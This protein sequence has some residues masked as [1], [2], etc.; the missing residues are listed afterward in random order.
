MKSTTSRILSAAGVRLFAIG[1]ACTVLMTSA[2]AATLTWSTA[3]NQTSTTTNQLRAVSVADQAGNDSVY[4][5]YIQ[6]TGANNRRVNQHST[7]APY[8]LLNQHLSSASEQPKGIAT[9]DRGNVFI[10]Y[11]NSGD[12][13]SFL[14]SHSSSLVTILDTSTNVSPVA[15]G[16]G[17]QKSGL[18]YY[19]YVTYETSGGRVE[20]YDVTDPMNITLDP[21]F[22]TGGVFFIPGANSLRGIEIGADGSLY[23]ASR[24]D[25]N[26][27]NPAAGRV[28]KVSSDLSTTS[29]VQLTRAMD[30]A[31]LG[32][33]VYATS[34]NGTNSLIR[35]LSAT[36][37]TTVED[38]TIAILDGNPYT[39]D[40]NEGWSGIDIDSSGR[41]W[42]G[43]QRYDN[44]GGTQDRLLV[45]SSLVPEPASAFLALVA[46]G[47][48]TLARR[49]RS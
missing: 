46:V 9:D 40:N 1:A 2:G 37:L 6:T 30:V 18:N 34:Y 35:V 23:V 41:I 43:D 29:F 15:G 38:I 39:R 32:G 47:V 16:V 11:R 19:A 42:L 27:P 3:V 10:S 33:N 36:D 12:T 20:R 24:D 25:S 5:G 7:T 17:V 44:V 48:C 49:R 22:G 14:R 21:T 26:L 4:V 28:Y 45:S 31:L 13:S 8:S